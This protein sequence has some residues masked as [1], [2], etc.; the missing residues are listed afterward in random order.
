M[1]IFSDPP[2]YI[3]SL[4]VPDTSDGFVKIVTC[5]SKRTPV[6]PPETVP[7]RWGVFV[8]CERGYESWGEVASFFSNCWIPKSSQ[9]LGPYR[10]A[11][12]WTST[13]GIRAKFLL[14]AAQHTHSIRI[15]TH[16]SSIL[17]CTNIQNALFSMKISK[18]NGNPDNSCLK[19]GHWPNLYFLWHDM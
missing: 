6:F 13:F 12:S 14:I 3:V 1:Q 15:K 17:T 4:H 9:R 7:E 5:I 10:Q 16:T 2:W 11:N 8:W 18:S 19:K